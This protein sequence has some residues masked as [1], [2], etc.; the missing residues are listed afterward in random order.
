MRTMTK[1]KSRTVLVFVVVVGSKALYFTG[2]GWLIP[3]IAL[4]FKALL[5]VVIEFLF[6]SNLFVAKVKKKKLN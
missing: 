2:F 3:R 6:S 1:Q 5:N 4:K